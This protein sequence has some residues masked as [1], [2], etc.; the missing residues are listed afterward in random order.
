LR[1]GEN[2]PV[3]ASQDSRAAT[4]GAKDRQRFE[5]PDQAAPPEA[6]QKLN[7]I[8]SV[9]TQA[10]A[11]HFHRKN[12]RPP[13]RKFVVEMWAHA[14]QA[15][16]LF[17]KEASRCVPR[18]DDGLRLQETVDKFQGHQIVFHRLTIGHQGVILFVRIS[19]GFRSEAFGLVVA[20][21]V[22]VPRAV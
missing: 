20:P 7:A 19:L 5:P 1:G 2:D 3:S 18:V 22:C 16:D 14:N 9:D 21:N 4:L 15:F 10:H 12:T 17:V 8:G 13:V 6:K 11:D